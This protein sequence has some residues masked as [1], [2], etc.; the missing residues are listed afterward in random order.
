MSQNLEIPVRFY[1]PAPGETDAQNG[2]RPVA[3][4]MAITSVCAVIQAV[5]PFLIG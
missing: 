1:R 3:L 5:N 4:K 2:E